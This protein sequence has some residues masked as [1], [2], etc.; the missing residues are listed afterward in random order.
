MIW[1]GILIESSN[2]QKL[3]S[4]YHENKLS[5]AFL[6]ETNN[7]KKCFDDIISLIKIINCPGEYKDKCNDCNLCELIKKKNLPSL[8]IINCDCATIKKEQIIE[9]INSFVTKPIFSKFNMYI[10][11]D[12]D[13]L[14]GSSGNTLL[15]FLEEPEEDILGFFITNNK[16]NVLSTVRSRC[17][18]VTCHYGEDGFE[19]DEEILDNV[20]IYLIN[21]YKNYDDLYYNK[22]NMSKLYNDR[23]KWESFFTVM[24]FYFK[25][26]L[27]NKRDDV[28]DVMKKFSQKNIIN[29]ILLIEEIL[30]L[31]KSN[32]NIDFILDK[33]VIEMRKYYE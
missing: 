18:I 1:G 17:Q 30:S 5:H 9:V 24:L 7:P 23:K 21:I 22:S 25:D 8:K 6:L 14:N 2:I 12:A 29:I 20:K 27:S 3:V 32:V 4:R 10:V 28:I 13:R 33:F 11:N 19:Y 15:K 16:E 26:C 31:I